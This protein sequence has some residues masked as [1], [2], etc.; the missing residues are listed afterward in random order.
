[1]DEFWMI[2]NQDWVAGMTQCSP[3]S[4]PESKTA[5]TTS[6]Q[7]TTLTNSK[8][9]RERKDDPPSDEE[10]SGSNKRLRDS[11]STPD[12]LNEKLKYA[13]PYRKHD[14]R[15]YNI[16]NWSPCALTPHKTVA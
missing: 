9:S 15:K 14:P 13:C 2:F 7:S 6:N 11:A 1:M 5:S 4:T 8:R 10:K 16:Q 12:D 3:D